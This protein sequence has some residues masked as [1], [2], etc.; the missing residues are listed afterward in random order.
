MSPAGAPALPTAPPPFILQMASWCWWILALS[1]RR[2]RLPSVFGCRAAILRGRSSS[3]SSSGPVFQQR[4]ATP[5]PAPSPP[6][7]STYEII[8]CGDWQFGDGVRPQDRSQTNHKR[9]TILS[10]A[11]SSFHNKS[12]KGFPTLHHKSPESFT[13]TVKSL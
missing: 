10:S 8:F 9:Q 7:Q 2:R 3:R 12:P 1:R 6:R 13:V 5:G 4:D 11:F